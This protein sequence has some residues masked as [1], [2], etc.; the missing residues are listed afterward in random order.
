ME[1]L[2]SQTCE[3]ELM[4]SHNLN[5]SEELSTSTNQDSDVEY[6]LTECS[7]FL[8]ESSQSESEYDEPKKEI[9][10]TPIQLENEPLS[11]SLASWAVKFKIPHVAL[12][13]LLKI[14][15]T[16][17]DSSLPQ[18]AR[19]LLQTPRNYNIKCIEPGYYYH[20]GLQN[21]LKNIIST[22]DPLKLLN[23]NCVE[24][25]IN[26]DGLPLS[27]SA[28]NQFYAVLQMIEMWIL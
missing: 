18:D 12:N 13:D 9:E 20:F 15:K 10:N 7:A 26:I 16:H 28:S 14:L 2:P 23:L 22:W 4:N 3:H 8:S 25:L 24:V 19:S 6:E 11:Q 1:D 5:T 17:D 21:C 27:K